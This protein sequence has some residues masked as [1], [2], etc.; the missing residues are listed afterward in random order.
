MPP[1]LIRKI[2]LHCL[3][4]DR[5]PR[6]ITVEAP[7]VL[8]HVC[9]FWRSVLIW[10]PEM[11]TA[12]ALVCGH[13]RIP[14]ERMLRTY[15][16]WV[17]RS[18]DHP[19]TLSFLF[20]DDAPPPTC[21]DVVDLDVFR[22]TLLKHAHRWRALYISSPIMC[23][24]VLRIQSI[25]HAP[26]S[27]PLLEGFSLVYNGPWRRERASITMSIRHIRQLSV[28]H[29][30]GHGC[31]VEL[32][33]HNVKF[34]NLVELRISSPASTILPILKYAPVLET[35]DVTFDLQER[36]HHCLAKPLMLCKLRTLKLSTH[37]ASLIPLIS[38]LRLPSLER[39]SV[40]MVSIFGV[41]EWQ[42]VVEL[43]E[44]SDP[45]L[46]ELYA[47]GGPPEPHIMIGLLRLVPDLT[48]LAGDWYMAMQ[49]ILNALT[50][51]ADRPPL[52]PQLE[53]FEF[54]HKF[55]TT[56]NAAPMVLSRWKH[57]DN[58]RFQIARPLE[59]KILGDTYRFLRYPGITECLEKG[60]KVS[61]E[62]RFEQWFETKGV[63]WFPADY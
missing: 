36:N 35:L 13:G 57:S 16:E 6:P 51:R 10:T 3:P 4:R 27:T 14:V 52:C 19:L 34:S 26:R 9:H 17:R 54:Q 11:W 28:L 22:S 50:V 25:L 53:R 58:A 62:R 55:S 43:V 8:G 32:S 56:E 29:L 33:M 42:N 49:P 48:L 46:R 39:L 40:T 24:C 12:L 60:L 5:L 38:Q 47:Y 63:D 59:V 15:E 44:R 37:D 23:R 41:E 18:G 30:G 61:D 21:N 31:L 20:A 7:L 45:P 2:F 1:E